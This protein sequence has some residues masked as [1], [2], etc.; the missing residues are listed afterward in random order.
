MANAELDHIHVM[1]FKY[2]TLA[3]NIKDGTVLIPL[4]RRPK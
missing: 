4:L 2:D 1:L 3:M